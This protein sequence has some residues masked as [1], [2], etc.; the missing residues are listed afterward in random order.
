[1]PDA[2]GKL[3]DDNALTVDG[4]E[5]VADLVR[6]SRIDHWS[7]QF[8]S[9]FIVQAHKSSHIINLKNDS[10]AY[11]ITHNLLLNTHIF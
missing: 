11:V 6:N 9:L 4:V 3:F 2:L 8:L 10:L 5:W 7:D 1:M